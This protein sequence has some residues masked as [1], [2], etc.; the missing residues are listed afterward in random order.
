LLLRGH[1]R[2][3]GGRN[4]KIARKAEKKKIRKL[5]TSRKERTDP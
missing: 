3:S 4:G 5:K 2:Y 1:D